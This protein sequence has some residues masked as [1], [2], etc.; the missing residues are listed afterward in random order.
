MQSLNHIVRDFDWVSVDGAQV[1]SERS[2]F[3]KKTSM[4]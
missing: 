2:P 1:T 4:V 3:E